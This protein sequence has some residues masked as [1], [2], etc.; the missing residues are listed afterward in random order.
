MPTYVERFKFS[1]VEQ[2]GQECIRD[3]L[4]MC[5]VHDVSNVAV[6]NVVKIGVKDVIAQQLVSVLQL[7]ERKNMFIVNQRGQISDLN[8]SKSEI[9][10]LQGELLRQSKVKHIDIDDEIVDR[11]ST[12]VQNSVESGIIKTYSEVAESQSRM[13]LV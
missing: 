3:L 13:L 11:L 12:A 7:I 8:G 6:E 5:K 1:E 2:D 10:R 9:I 4:K